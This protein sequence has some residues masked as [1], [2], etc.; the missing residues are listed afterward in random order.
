MDARGQLVCSLNDPIT[1]K[2]FYDVLFIRRD[3]RNLIG[4]G[5]ADIEYDH[6]RIVF[7]DPLYGI[8]INCKRDIIA[9][10]CKAATI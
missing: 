10:L 5:Y 9:I 1:T 8:N 7:S 4:T 2:G 6:T 3:T